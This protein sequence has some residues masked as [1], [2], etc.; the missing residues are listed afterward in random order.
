MTVKSVIV[1][2]T[3]RSAMPCSS[4]PRRRRVERLARRHEC[5]APEQ[6]L[7]VDAEDGRVTRSEGGEEI[8]RLVVADVSRRA[9]SVVAKRAADV[10]AGGRAAVAREI[11]PVVA[12]AAVAAAVAQLREK[13]ADHPLIAVVPVDARRARR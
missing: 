5:L 1:R 12:G 2:S 10:A 9:A 3:M 11:R 7:Q 13:V 6:P 8:L 4:S